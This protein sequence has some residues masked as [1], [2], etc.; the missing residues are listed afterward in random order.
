MNL[1]V[2]LL[3]SFGLVQWPLD[4]ALWYVYAVFIMALFSP[5]LLL[6]FKN[7]KIAFMITLILIVVIAARVFVGTSSF[8]KI[9]NYG[10]IPNVLS[11]LPCYLFGAYLGKYCTRLKVLDV[12]TRVY[13]IIIS[14]FVLQSAFQGFFANTVIKIMPIIAIFALTKVPRTNMLKVLYQLTFLM[15]AIHQPLIGDI[16]L[17][18][19]AIVG[20]YS[21]PISLQNLLLRLIILTVDVIISFIIFYLLHNR[22]PRILKVFTGGRG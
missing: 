2:F 8:V 4:G 5:V 13:I 15:Y 7:E 17:R 9:L 14:A 12:L 22:F 6:I 16:K 3:K 1:R 21:M 18:I 10:Y 20:K 11:Y 19:V